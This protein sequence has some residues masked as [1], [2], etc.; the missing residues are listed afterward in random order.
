[1]NGLKKLTCQLPIILTFKILNYGESFCLL[2]F[3]DRKVNRGEEKKPNPAPFNKAYYF[4]KKIL[5]F[6]IATNWKLSY[7]P[8]QHQQI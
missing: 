8:D 2:L 4:I 7:L 6:F 1:M 3:T 5:K